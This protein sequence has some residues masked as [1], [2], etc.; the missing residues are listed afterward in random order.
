MTTELLGQAQTVEASVQADGDGR[1]RRAVT[2]LA[3][4]IRES[5][6][7]ISSRAIGDQGSRY[8]EGFLRL[9]QP[10]AD[11]ELMHPIALDSAVRRAIVALDAV[12][13]EECELVAARFIK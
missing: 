3:I 4:K 2:A 11:F 1:S 5:A 8:I 12:S 13:I 6:M 7:R 9:E 10:Y